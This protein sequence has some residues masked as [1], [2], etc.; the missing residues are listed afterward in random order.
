MDITVFDNTFSPI[1]VVDTVES[2]IWTERYSNVGDF[3]LFVGASKYFLDLLKPDYYLRIPNSEEFMIIESQEIKSDIDNGDK[4]LIKGR[5]L[6]SILDRRVVFQRT[7]ISSGIQDAIW[8]LLLE[9]AITPPGQVQRT[10]PGFV[11][12]YSADP[13][14]ITPALSPTVTTEYYGEGLLDVIQFLCDRSKLGFKLL[15][16]DTYNFEFSLYVGKDRSYAQSTNPFVVFSP[17]F[18][19]LMSSD[20]FFTQKF[21]KTIALIMGDAY[22]VATRPTV[23]FDEWENDPTNPN[24]P[25]IRTGLDRRELFVDAPDL[26]I[27]NP[28]T[29]LPYTDGVTYTQMLYERARL[30]LRKNVGFSTFDGETD[31]T[32]Q[33]KYGTDFNLGDIVQLEDAYGNG[34]RARVT[35]FVTSENLAGIKMFPTFEII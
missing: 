24:Y 4:L 7:I 14:V 15:H 19:N 33:F 23:D 18:D 26:S 9:N 17:S 8:T 22:N 11:F 32:S 35:E 13:L 10:I 12:T 20:Y 3:E 1:S 31:S 25:T 6:S 27:I 30:D 21:Y 34:G 28:A 5:S 16:N 29:G 2:V